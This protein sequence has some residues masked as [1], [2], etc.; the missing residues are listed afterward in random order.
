MDRYESQHPEDETAPNEK[1]YYYL[2]AIYYLGVQKYDSTEY[3]LR[4]SQNEPHDLN[5]RIAVAKGFSLLYEKTGHPD[6]LTKYARLASDL[7]DTLVSQI[8]TENILHFDKM[9]QYERLQ[10]KIQKKTKETERARTAAGTLLLLSILLLATCAYAITA[11]RRKKRQA[12]EQYLEDQE[13]LERLQDIIEQLSIEKHKAETDAMKADELNN[14]IQE[15]QAEILNLKER[16]KKYEHR[17]KKKNKATIEQHFLETPVY[18]KLRSLAD[19]PT[20]C[21]TE[22]DW[23][24]LVAT[25]NQVVPNFYVTIHQNVSVLS[26]TEYRICML[27]WLRFAPSEM[28]N[29]IG[30]SKVHISILRIRLL[31]KIFGKE[32]STKEFDAK[33]SE[34]C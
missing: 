10:A 32:G 25:F 18:K 21:P 22:E 27:T 17:T 24:E 11:F 5:D 9:Y 28:C 6:S 2:K 13:E 16:I 15:A 7:Q 8:E 34:I 30:I 4:K 33:I 31:K 3:Y 29:L 12:L 20:S 26:E 19:K 1:I 14:V 23:T